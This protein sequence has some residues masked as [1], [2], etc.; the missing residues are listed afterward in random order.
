MPIRNGRPLFNLLAQAF[1]LSEQW[2]RNGT[3]G[4][5]GVM[6]SG[7][8][9]A[10][11]VAPPSEP[12]HSYQV[13]TKGADSPFIGSD[14]WQIATPLVQ[15]FWWPEWTVRNCPMR[16]VTMSVGEVHEPVRNDA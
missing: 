13:S 9:N 15:G 3:T 8:H 1:L 7:G 16:P 12:G 5:H 14:E 6:T 11:I 4:V 10:S 2:W